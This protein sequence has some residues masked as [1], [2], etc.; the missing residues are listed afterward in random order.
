MTS[1]TGVSTVQYTVGKTKNEISR[2]SAKHHLALPTI[3]PNLK[4]RRTPR[5]KKIRRF[6]QTSGIQ[7]VKK[8]YKIACFFGSKMR[9]RAPPPPVAGF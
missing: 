9:A 2:G 4:I 1:W 6:R 5:V 8:T 3:G 7:E